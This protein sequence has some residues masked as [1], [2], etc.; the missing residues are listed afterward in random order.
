MD[1]CATGFTTSALWFLQQGDSERA[2]EQCGYVIKDI[3]P[4][5]DEKDLVGLHA[6][7]LRIVCMLKWNGNTDRAYKVYEKYAP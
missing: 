4:S 3:L 1:R 6:I 2:I 7:L 5:Y